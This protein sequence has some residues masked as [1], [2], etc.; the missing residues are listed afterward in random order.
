M[1]IVSKNSLGVKASVRVGTLW[2]ESGKVQIKLNVPTK[3]RLESREY[4]Y[5]G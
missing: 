1:K 5:I 3:D 2:A 4:S